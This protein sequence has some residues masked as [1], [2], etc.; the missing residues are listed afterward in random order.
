MVEAMLASLLMEMLAH[1]LSG[2]GI[3][4]ANEEA[5][6]LHVQGAPDLTWGRAVIGGI[7]F[8]V[9]IQVHRALTELVIAERFER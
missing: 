2:F 7:D 9:A 3:E 8:D 4:E 6:P 1:E 5:I